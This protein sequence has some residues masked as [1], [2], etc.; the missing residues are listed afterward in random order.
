MDFGDVV[1]NMDVTGSMGGA[2]E[3]LKDNLQTRIIPILGRLI[4]DLGIGVTRFADYPC[5]DYGVSPDEPFALAQR[6]TTD[7]LAAQAA[8]SGLSLQNGMDLPESGFES[9]YQ[10]A[11]GA[12]RASECPGHA[13]TA[14]FDPD[15]DEI[16]GVAD[17][18]QGGGGLRDE[19][20]RG[21]VQI[22]AANSHATGDAGYPYGATRSETYAALEETG[23]HVIGLAVGTSGLLGAFDSPAT[24]DLTEMAYE[25][26]AV[27]PPCAW[28]GF[29][30]NP[31]CAVG[32]CC[33]RL[34]GAGRAPDRDGLCPLSFEVETGLPIPIPGMGGG[35]GVSDGVI[36]GIAALLGGRLFDITSSLRR[37]EDEFAR[38][39]VDTT[40]FINGIVP[41]GST[42]RGCA[43]D[44][45]PVDTDG[46]D[47]LDGFTGVSPGTTVTFEVRAQNDCVEETYN[48]QTFVVYIDLIA[49]DGT[50]L[51]T[52]IV[53]I[54]VPPR[55]PK[56]DE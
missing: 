27:V 39:G 23:V 42:P 46:D 31:D 13:G 14:A 8:V 4:S 5:D 52:K 48:P 28:D 21:A 15:A 37:D 36:S 26:D 34:D 35:G 18:T 30:T 24:D 12:G 29:R 49:D 17:G 45:T 16:P 19:T 55:D 41:I 40:C 56:E 54:L 9:L 51:G 38:S 11:T 1:F 43:V 53:T 44:P 6:V 2:I 47:V 50:G 10:M 25:T 32:Q 7:N 33:T 20:S 22:T 3:S